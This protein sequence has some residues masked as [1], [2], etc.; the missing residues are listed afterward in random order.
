M[1]L[2]MAEREPVPR[3]RF[4][5]AGVAAVA[6]ALLD[7]RL[8]RPQPASAAGVFAPSKA[9]D[10]ALLRSR[11]RGPVAGLEPLKKNSPRMAAFPPWLEGT[12]DVDAALLAPPGEKGGETSGV[13]DA[14]RG[15]V[16]ARMRFVT[17]GKGGVA[18]D[19]GFNPK[20]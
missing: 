7:T 18:E 3:R 1:T 15:V 8:S 20:P 10:A 5:V 6:L 14:L 16:G 13:E 2:R 17:K 11:L 4:S 12:W 9:D 19:R